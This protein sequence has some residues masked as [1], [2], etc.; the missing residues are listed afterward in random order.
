MDIEN[1]IDLPGEIWK[2]YYH[3]GTFI[4]NYGR[5]HCENKIKRGAITFE[6]LLS[7][8]HDI[9]YAPINYDN[10]IWKPAKGFESLYE[11]SDKGR[12]KSVSK[13]N[14]FKRPEG[15]IFNNDKGKFANITLYKNNKAHN[16]SVRTIIAETFL[17]NPYRLEFAL[18]KDLFQANYNGA[19][20]LFW[21]SM[22]L[23]PYHLKS[24][25][26]SIYYNTYEW[27]YE[28]DFEWQ[29]KSYAG[30]LKFIYYADASRAYEFLRKHMKLSCRNPETN[31][32]QF[33][34][35]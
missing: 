14:D 26:S 1:K 9:H 6:K 18:Y 7:V 27:V 13:D 21:T 33:R 4:S 5:A 19:D 22:P 2:P 23:E 31:P 12:I 25:N 35:Q 32:E 17:P 29:E 3:T 15:I 30:R 16:C 20:N 8:N 11:A 28:F 24:P 10:E 34:R